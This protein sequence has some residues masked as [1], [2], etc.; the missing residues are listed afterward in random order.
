MSKGFYSAVVFC[1][2]FIF[3]ARIA[4]A[5]IFC[6]NY[7]G[8]CIVA[9]AL[10]LNN[11]EAVKGLRPSELVKTETEVKAGIGTKTGVGTVSV[12]CRGNKANIATCVA[13]NAQGNT[14]GTPGKFKL[15]ES[16]RLVLQE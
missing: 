12:F 9:K 6:G 1:L 16:G 13:K 14:I 5:C 10:T 2:I 15:T 3:A 11:F 4:E 8:S 7:D